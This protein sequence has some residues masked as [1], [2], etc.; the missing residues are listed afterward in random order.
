MTAP[1]LRPFRESDR[2]FI[3][4][5]WLRSYYQ[6]AFTY[7]RPKISFETYIRGHRRVIQRLMPLCRIVV[8][9]DPEHLDTII[10]WCASEP[11]VLHYMHVKELFR[12]NGFMQ[13]ML[14]ASELSLSDVVYSHVTKKFK[15][16]VSKYPEASFNPWA[17]MR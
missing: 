2:D 7:L 6:G 1:V 13:E 4:A 17:M 15:D 5:T 14:K 12:R 11:P 16:I 8:M 3:E 9:A 10:G